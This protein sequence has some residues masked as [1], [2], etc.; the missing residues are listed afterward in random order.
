MD[1]STHIFEQYYIIVMSIVKFEKKVFD[2]WLED[3]HSW[4]CL[5]CHFMIHYDEEFADSNDKKSLH[6]EAHIPKVLVSFIWII[7]LIISSGRVISF[8]PVSDLS[9]QPAL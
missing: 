4:F 8:Q 6:P 9:D 1:H 5:W 3:H 7:P 2:D